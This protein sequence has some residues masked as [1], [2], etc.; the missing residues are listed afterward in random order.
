[1][2]IT[3]Y[4]FEKKS[5]AAG[6]KRRKGGFPVDNPGPIFPISLPKIEKLSS[7]KNDW[8]MIKNYFETFGGKRVGFRA[9]LPYFRDQ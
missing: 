8:K 3:N 2:E 5:P 1:M 7:N 9:A 6:D 4:I